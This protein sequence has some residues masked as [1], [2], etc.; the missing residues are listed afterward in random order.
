MGLDMYL[1]KKTYVKRWDF[2]EDEKKHKVTVRL[3]G[4]VRKDIKADRIS[5]IVEEVGYWRKA[6]HIHNWFVQNVQDGRDECQESYLEI[7][8]LKEL[9]DVCKAVVEKKDEEFSK[10]HLPTESGFFFGGTEYDEY[11]YQDCEET[12]KMLDE[13][14]KDEDKKPDACYG[15][16]YYYQASW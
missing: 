5:Y 10:E 4:K 3:G 2:Q 6:N 1:S 12:I 9:R 7:E 13:V 16:D 8:Q 15:A 11:Y 14:I